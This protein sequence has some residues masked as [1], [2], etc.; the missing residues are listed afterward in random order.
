MM[1]A[2]SYKNSVRSIQFLFSC[3]YILANKFL[4][5]QLLRTKSN[6]IS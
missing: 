3:K 4:W 1:T 2:P 6:F 5:K